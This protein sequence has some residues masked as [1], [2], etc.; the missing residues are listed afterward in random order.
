MFACKAD[1]F[2]ASTATTAIAAATSIIILLYVVDY[3]TGWSILFTSA[4][5]ILEHFY[6]DP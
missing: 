1:T 4:L 2:T 5:N 3:D 6:S